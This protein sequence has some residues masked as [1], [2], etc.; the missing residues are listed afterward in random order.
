MILL[1]IINL[2]IQGVYLRSL[3]FIGIFIFFIT[4]CA[5]KLQQPIEDLSLPQQAS[6]YV[7][8]NEDR[9]NYRLK[10]QLKEEYLAKHFIVWKEGFKSPSKEEMFWGLNMKNGWGESKRIIDVNF[11]DRLQASMNIDKYPSIKKKAIT[12]KTTNVRLFPTIKPRYS[13]INGY[14]FDRWQNSLIFAFTPVSVL[15]QDETKEWYLIQSSF[16]SGW[17]KHDEIGFVSDDI[18][19][20]SINNKKFLIPRRD[21][22]PL[23]DKN[24]NFIENARIGML[25]EAKNNNEVYVYKIDSNKNVKKISI[26]INRNDFSNFPIMINDSNIARIMD[27]LDRENYGWGGMYGNRD[28]SSFIRDIFMNFGIWLPR[29]SKAQVEYGQ[30]KP[31]SKFM[32]L[33]KDSKEKIEF[34]KANAKPFRTILWQQGHIMLYIGELDGKP[35]VMHDVWGINT[36]DGVEVL[37]GITVTT[38]EPGVEKNR[39]SAPPTLLDRIQAMNIV[40][41][42]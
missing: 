18:V 3:L 22:I 12:L 26:S 14:P 23:Y 41:N 9:I 21:Y 35:L 30:L 4:G 1:H 2:V 7:K 38:L 10:N 33:P 13:S 16:V 27:V 32:E 36:T 20:S 11:F 19:K 25:F 8:K 24:N 31:Y 28:C 15:H 17:V 37:G 6:F 39:G 5:T 34:I 29:N 42:Y 40:M